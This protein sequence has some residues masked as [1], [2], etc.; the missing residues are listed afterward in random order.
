MFRIRTVLA[1]AAVAAA[2]VLAFAAP[3]SAH[4]ELVQSSPAADEQLTVAPE[5]VVLTF[6]NDL[7]SLE[8]NSG[9]AMTVVDSSGEDWV[10]G[11][12]VVQADTVTVPLEEGMPNG[13]Y[14]VT[15]KVVSS[16]GHPTDGQYAFSLAAEDAEATAEPTEEASDEPS[17]QP[18]AEQSPASASDDGSALAPVL[19]GIGGLIVVAAIVTAV[20]LARRR[21]A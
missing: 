6:S 17:E 10:A 4:D 1:G 14:T 8:D 12:P 5:Q 18:T 20:V 16:D 2:A 21:R 15:W 19:W 11:E 3:A 13:D 7:L 9:T